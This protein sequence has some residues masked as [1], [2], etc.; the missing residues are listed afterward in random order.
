MSYINLI[1]DLLGS[2]PVIVEH[3]E[4][5]GPDPVTEQ[6]IQDHYELW[7]QT[8]LAPRLHGFKALLQDTFKRYTPKKKPQKNEGE[9]P[10]P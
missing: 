1:Q 9:D 5:F 4:A 7:K 6:I 2:L 3:L 8:H 10:M